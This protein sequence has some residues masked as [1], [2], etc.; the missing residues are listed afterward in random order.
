M[1]DDTTSQGGAGKDNGDKKKTKNKINGSGGDDASSKK[2]EALDNFFPEEL[3]GSGVDAKKS[4]NNDKS[5][6]DS[7]DEI[8]SGD[9]DKKSAQKSEKTIEQASRL[10]K[11]EKEKVQRPSKKVGISSKPDVKM[12]EL[13]EMTP[14]NTV[15]IDLN[16][17]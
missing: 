2:S 7:S 16:L 5:K 15:T 9:V 12:A 11:E 8:K 17:T 4:K 6:L 1:A 10:D 13:L 14:P 3:K